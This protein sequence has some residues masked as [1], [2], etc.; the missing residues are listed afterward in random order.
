MIKDTRGSFV[1]V[2]LESRF[3][4]QGLATDFREDYFSFS[5]AGVLRGLHFQLPPK[6]HAKLV[7]CLQG[8]VLDVAL[9][10][11]KGSPTFGQH[12]IFEL[13]GDK[14]NM[15]YLPKGLAHGFYAV[16]GPAVL[17]YKVTSEYDSK[18]D[19]GILWNSAG[20]NWPTLSPVMS[21]RDRS[22]VTLAEFNSPFTFE[23]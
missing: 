2:F 12:Q 22:F 13:S 19:T 11:R 14:A 3:Q 5:N 9:D 7:Y 17:V 23:N 21:D 20:I 10:L 4:E 15:L 16:D 8:K 6:D 1:K 18:C